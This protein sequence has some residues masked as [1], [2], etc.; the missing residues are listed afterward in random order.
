MASV[1]LYWVPLGAG[2]RFVKLNGAIY[3]RVCAI[4]ERRPAQRLF[5]SALEVRIDDDTY[6]IELCPEVRGEHGRV[7]G[8]PVG[9]RWAGRLRIFRYEARCWR[10]GE[11]PDIAYA[12]GGPRIVSSDP[13]VALALIDLVPRIP[14][15][16][17]GRDEFG[18]GEM[19]N[20]NSVIAWLLV[21]AGVEV[22]ELVP[23]DGGRAPGW[24][25]GVAVARGSAQSGQSEMSPSS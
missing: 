20:S 18:A 8:G 22:N 16:V 9:S 12:I 25:A 24:D 2:G 15:P 13:D 11:I 1:A 6:A 3:E 14:T 5:H 7:A 17:W 23:P 10:G 19:W 4:R 21:S